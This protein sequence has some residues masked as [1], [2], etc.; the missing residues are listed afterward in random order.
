MKEIFK[1]KIIFGHLLLRISIVFLFVGLIIYLFFPLLYFFIFGEG[2][3][4]HI[5]EKVTLFEFISDVLPLFIGLLICLF[6]IKRNYKTNQLKKAKSYLVTAILLVLLYPFR[7][8][9]IDHVINSCLYIS[10]KF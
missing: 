5:S 8:F 10:N 9:F 4:N 7:I 3:T 6:K 2:S 1:S